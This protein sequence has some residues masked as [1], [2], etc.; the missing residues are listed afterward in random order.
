[1]LAPGNA[2]ELVAD[3]GFQDSKCGFDP[4]SHHA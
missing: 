1:M 2:D 4:W 3:D